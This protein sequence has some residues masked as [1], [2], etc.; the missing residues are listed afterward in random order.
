MSKLKKIL[1]V[2]KILLSIFFLWSIIYNLVFAA[3][4]NEDS[5]KMNSSKACELYTKWTGSW[6]KAYDEYCTSINKCKWIS[7]INEWWTNILKIQ[8]IPFVQYSPDS[9][10]WQINISQQAMDIYTAYYTNIWLGITPYNV[11]WPLEWAKAV[12][13]E[14][15]NA[16][17]NCAILNTKIKVWINI[18]NLVKNTKNWS[19]IENK[20]RSQN[21]LFQKE[22][23]KRKCNKVWDETIPYNEIL[24]KNMTYH[25]CNYRMYLGYLSKYSNDNIAPNKSVTSKVKSVWQDKYDTNKAFD[26]LKIQKGAVAN[27][28]QHAKDIYNM[29]FNWF[30]ELESTYWSHIMLQFIYDDY[31]ALRDNL[32]KLLA[33]LSQLAYKIP[34]AQKQ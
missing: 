21:E 30:N 26:N 11:W 22:L 1:F 23:E 12:Y 27:E 4:T 18:I 5:K 19:N 20:I 3:D 29:S 24:L 33:P 16:I 10:S 8:M 25:Y 34:H 7:E 32:G 14:T 28:I 17:Y 9:N 2:L 15:Q 13:V 6:D 31:V